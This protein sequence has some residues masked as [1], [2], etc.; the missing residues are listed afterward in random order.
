MTSRAITSVSV[1]GAVPRATGV[2]LVVA[3]GVGGVVALI[4]KV[5]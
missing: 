1:A 2:G 4:P 3:A 5:Y